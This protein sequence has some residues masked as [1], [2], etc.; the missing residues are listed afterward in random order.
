MAERRARGEGGGALAVL[1]KAPIP[2]YAKVRLVPLLGPQGAAELHAVLLERTLRIAGSAGFDPVAVWCAPDRRHPSFEALRA[3]PPLELRDQPQGDLGARMLA[4]F[5]LHLGAGQPVVLI[6]TDC[7]ELG[8]DHL[9]AARAALASG[10]DVALLPAADGGYAAIG[11]ARVDRTLFDG[12]RWGSSEV[13]EETRRRIRRL[14]WTAH[15][16]SPLRDVDRPEDVEWLLAS[17]LLGEDERRRIE[18]HLP[19]TPGGTR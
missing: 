3:G 5:E 2:G 10:A 15:E 4:A 13:L 8:P 18:R 17:G 16:L 9:R 1:A 19:W 6:G 14:G 7:P 11:L 12:V